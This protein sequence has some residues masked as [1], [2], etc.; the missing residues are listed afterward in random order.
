MKLLCVAGE[1]RGREIA[2][3]RYGEYDEELFRMDRDGGDLQQISAQG[4]DLLT[5][6]WHPVC[7]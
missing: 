6:A 3:V 7:R 2:F 4:D 5:P 1:L